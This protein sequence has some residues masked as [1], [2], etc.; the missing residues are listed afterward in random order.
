MLRFGQEGTELMPAQ[1]KILDITR[2]CNRER[3]DFALCRHSEFGCKSPT[4]FEHVL[5]AMNSSRVKVTVDHGH[6]VVR[7]KSF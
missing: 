6:A 3:V 2:T 5:L 4:E 1:E 7:L